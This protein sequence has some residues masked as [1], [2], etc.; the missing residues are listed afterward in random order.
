MTGDPAKQLYGLLRAHGVK[1]SEVAGDYVATKSEAL[2]C[3]E[4]D[5]KYYCTIGYDALK[6]ALTPAQYCD[7]E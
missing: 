1:T 2:N 5:G 4:T 7:L 6:N 3:S